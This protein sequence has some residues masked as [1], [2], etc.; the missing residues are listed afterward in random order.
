MVLDMESHLNSL[1]L[2][3]FVIVEAQRPP[4]RT[5]K[6]GP[7]RPTE[8]EA[9]RTIAGGVKQM[10]GKAAPRP[11]LT[12]VGLEPRRNCALIDPDPNRVGTPMEA[13]LR[14]TPPMRHST[15]PP[16]VR[17]PNQ[18]V[19]APVP[20]ANGDVGCDTIRPRAGHDG[21]GNAMTNH[22]VPQCSTCSYL[23]L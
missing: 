13:T 9:Q 12:P 8:K 19:K 23:I 15:G 14:P 6:D 10:P 4:N 2:L 5:T 21:E 11:N 3:F 1:T 16:M 20:P 17:H 7:T 22:D 18:A